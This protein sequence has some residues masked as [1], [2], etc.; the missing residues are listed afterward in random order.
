M[1]PPGK[2][3][4]GWSWLPVAFQPLMALKPCIPVL[5]WT[6]SKLSDWG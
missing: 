1:K 4:L 2:G 6:L 5:G 3:L